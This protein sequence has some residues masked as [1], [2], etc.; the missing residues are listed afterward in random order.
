M[1]VARSYEVSSCLTCVQYPHTQILTVQL[2]DANIKHCVA[3]IAAS[4][5]GERLHGFS[6]SSL[7][8]LKPNLG[9]RVSGQHIFLSCKLPLHPLQLTMYTQIPFSVLES[10]PRSFIRRSSNCSGHSCRFY[11]HHPDFLSSRSKGLKMHQERSIL[12][13]H[14][15]RGEILV[16][17]L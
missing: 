3:H 12:Q 11:P 15:M 4:P 13:G 14:G 9:T 5:L 10:P 8:N 7:L 17:V 6:S 16:Q 2:W 1:C